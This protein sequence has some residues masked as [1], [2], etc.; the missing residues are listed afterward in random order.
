M[1]HKPACSDFVHH[2]P[3]SKV[4]SLGITDFVIFYSYSTMQFE[5]PEFPPALLEI[6]T[7]WS[8]RDL[9]EANEPVPKLSRNEVDFVFPIY[10]VV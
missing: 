9:T 7:P 1:C 8:L 4:L 2:R 10:Q 6:R 5:P 3:R